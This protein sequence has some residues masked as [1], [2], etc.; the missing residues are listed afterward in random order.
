MEPVGGRQVAS[1]AESTSPP[2]SRKLPNH[3]RQAAARS[4]SISPVSDEREVGNLT[5]ILRIGDRDSPERLVFL[6]FAEIAGID[7]FAAVG[8]ERF[9]QGD[10]RSWQPTSTKPTPS[11]GTNSAARTWRN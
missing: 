1:L 6:G 9:T 3:L 5:E 2:A 11:S 10:W 8:Y 4:C 7:G